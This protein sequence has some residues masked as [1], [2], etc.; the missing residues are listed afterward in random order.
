MKTRKNTHRHPR[1]F[2]DQWEPWVENKRRHSSRLTSSQRLAN[3]ITTVI[4]AAIEA[5][6]LCEIE[7]FLRLEAQA[8]SRNHGVPGALLADTNPR[9]KEAEQAS[10]WVNRPAKSADEQETSKNCRQNRRNSTTTTDRKHLPS[11]RGT[12]S[13]SHALADQDLDEEQWDQALASIKRLQ[14]QT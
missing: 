9:K 1:G 5:D 6:T 2:G 4:Q 3:G 7:P 10:E 13:Q 14:Q 12:A 8:K 11:E